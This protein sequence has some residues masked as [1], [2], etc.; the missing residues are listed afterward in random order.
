MAIRP[1][2]PKN[3]T[4]QIDATWDGQLGGIVEVKQGYRLKFDIPPTFGGPGQAFCP[5][6]LLLASIAG[7]LINTFLHFKEQIEFE[8]VAFSFQVRAEVGF[9][10]DKYQIIQIEVDGTLMVSEGNE[11]LGEECLRLAK[12]YCHITRSLTPCIPI[13]YHIGIES[14]H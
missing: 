6:E 12:D 9:E 4:F 3:L 14:A 2:Y 13:K 11:D 5:D 8:M 10:H 1:K 7:C